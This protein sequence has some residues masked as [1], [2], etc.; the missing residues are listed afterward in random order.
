M[1]RDP[2]G[3]FE[4][5]AQLVAALREFLE[6][7]HSSTLAEEASAKLETVRERGESVGGSLDR[8]KREL[9]QVFD[10]CR[11]GFRSALTIWPDNAFAQRQL[12]AALEVMIDYE[13]DHGSFE[14]AATL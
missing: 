8:R 9:N 6:H 13:L 5:A 4:T 2:D 14:V 7:R 12:Q 3:R 10:E 1:Q 11:F